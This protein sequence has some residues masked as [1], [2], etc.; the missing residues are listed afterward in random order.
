MVFTGSHQ[1]WSH[2]GFV[3]PCL[4]LI[5]LQSYLFVKGLKPKPWLQTPYSLNDTL[6]SVC[7]LP[8]RKR[9]VKDN[10]RIAL[11]QVKYL[12]HCGFSSI[13]AQIQVVLHSL[14][15]CVKCT[16]WRS[17]NQSYSS[18]LLE[19]SLQGQKFKFFQGNGHTCKRGNHVKDVF[20]SLITIL[21]SKSRPPFH[22]GL[23]SDDGQQKDMKVV[24]L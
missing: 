14:C 19:V 8:C 22:L 1:N 18:I 10:T 5:S 20:A 16:E 13:L 2:A 6:H 15:Y 7:L 9:D 3:I 11:L 21:S 23:G 12:L 24:C 4:Q 17:I